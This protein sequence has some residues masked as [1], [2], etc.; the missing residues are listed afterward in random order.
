MP[1]FRFPDRINSNFEGYNAFLNLWEFG[2]DKMFESI[3]IDFQENIWFEA[4][5]SACLGAVISKFEESYNDV[6][7]IN[8]NYSLN[9]ILSKNGF[10]LNFGGQTVLDL[11]NTTVSYKKYKVTEEK[12]IKSY[13]DEK[14]LQKDEFPTLSNLLRKKIGES[15]FEIFSNADIHGGCTHVYSCGQYF[16]NKT[17][18]KLDFTIVD[19]GKT[20][21]RNVSDFTEQP[22]KGVDAIKWAISEGNTTKKGNHPGGLGLKIIN[23]FI[24]LNKGKMQI[25]SADGYWEIAN[26]LEFSSSFEFNFPGTIINL[27]FKLDDSNKYHLNT[28]IG[29]DDIF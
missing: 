15:I 29:L 8:M 17:P 2:N 12:L 7:F 10:L 11:Y 18:P 23:E 25:V 14:L 20:I 16:P 22:I 1:T 27:E 28:E 4:N 6:Q 9:N 24:R 26:N 5:L 21:K 13:L 19:L 3:I